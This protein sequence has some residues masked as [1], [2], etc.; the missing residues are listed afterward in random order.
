MYGDSATKNHQG[1][2]FVAGQITGTVLGMAIGAGSP[3]AL[4]TGLKVGYRVLEGAQILGGAVNAGQN[5]AEGNYL[6]AFGDAVG[7]VGGIASFMKACFVAGTP[8]RTPEGSKPVEQFRAGDLVLSRD[9]LDP[10]G[11]VAAKQVVQTFVRVSPIL[12]LHVGGRIIGT[13]AEHPFFVRGKG[14]VDAHLLRL[15]DELQTSDGRWLACEG[16]AY[17]GRVEAVYNME[18]EDYHTYF[19][20]D[21]AWGWDVWA[22]N[23]KYLVNDKSIAGKS[24]S[25]VRT[26]RPQGWTEKKTHG[27]GWRQIDENGVERVRYMYPKKN[28]KWAHEETGYFRRQNANGEFLDMHGNVV[29]QTDPLFHVKTHIIPGRF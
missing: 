7:V 2:Y 4:G 19:V 11:A 3:C 23:A 17:S 13:T 15:G 21:K 9:E 29:P 12:N 18:V 24:P 20:G 28:G 22:H 6:A 14:W 5:L 8:I 27:H 16:V 26:D 25:R 1:G 10:N